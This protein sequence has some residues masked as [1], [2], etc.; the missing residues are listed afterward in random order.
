MVV[1]RALDIKAHR[2]F[3]QAW[4][5]QAT[6]RRRAE[7]TLAQGFQSQC[8]Q[9]QCVQNQ[10]RRAQSSSARAIATIILPQF[11]SAVLT[12][13]IGNSGLSGRAGVKAG[14]PFQRVVTASIGKWTN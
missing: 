14:A 6:L 7:R 9:N 2:R 12:V 5:Q 8:F 13:P 1:S 10:G 3:Q 11:A 4:F